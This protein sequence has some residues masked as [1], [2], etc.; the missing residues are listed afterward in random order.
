M[1][2]EAFSREVVVP[3][4]T[5][6]AF[7]SRK[8]QAPGLAAAITIA[9]ATGFDLG[10]LAQ[11]ETLSPLPEAEQQFLAN[12]RQLSQEDRA[13]VASLASRLARTTPQPEDHPA[14]RHRKRTDKQAKIGERIATK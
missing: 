2:V 12:L 11:N 8:S 7:L 9:R 14:S 4:S 3:G 13:F 1:D 10:S 6:R 5:V